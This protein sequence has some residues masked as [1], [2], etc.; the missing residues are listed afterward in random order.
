[1]SAT[2]TIERLIDASPPEQQSQLVT[3]LAQALDGVISQTLVRTADSR[4][5]KAIVEVLV[6]TP[7]IAYLLMTGKVFQIPMKLETGAASGMQLMDHALVAALQQK[8]IDPDDAYLYAH[9][10]RLFQKFVTDPNLLA[11]GLEDSLG[12]A[13]LGCPR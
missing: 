4:S 5:R 2:K 10:K 9:D 11:A 12:S 1:V 3:S 7:A 13:G 8:Q 6:M